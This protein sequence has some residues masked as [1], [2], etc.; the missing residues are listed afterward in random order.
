MFNF[1]CMSFAVSDTTEEA[2]EPDGDNRDDLPRQA[3]AREVI[4]AN[5]GEKALPEVLEFREGG[6]PIAARHVA[7]VVLNHAL[8]CTKGA[9]GDV[10]F[11]HLGHFRL[12]KVART[13]IGREDPL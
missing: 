5:I 3:H 2:G 9:G 1:V 12:E 6:N 7:D 4:V 13:S 10:I 11:Q 8:T